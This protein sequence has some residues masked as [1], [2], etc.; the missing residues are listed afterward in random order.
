M[1]ETKTPN[2]SKA[3]KT[4]QS[5]SPVNLKAVN[6]LLLKRE[7]NNST[8]RLVDRPTQLICISDI[9]LLYVNRQIQKT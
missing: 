4:Y 3:S 9:Y 7:E 5:V 6:Q 1:A 2:K 8:E